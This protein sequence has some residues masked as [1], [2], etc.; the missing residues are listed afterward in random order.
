MIQLSSALR[1][2]ALSC[3]AVLL[4]G[5]SDSLDSPT[6]ALPTDEVALARKVGSSPGSPDKNK[7][8]DQEGGSRKSPKEKNQCDGEGGG[9]GGGGGGGDGPLWVSFGWNSDECGAVSPPRGDR[10]NVE[11]T[12]AM[13]DAEV[14]LSDISWSLANQ[15]DGTTWSAVDTY[16]DAFSSF[17][18]FPYDAF[19]CGSPGGYNAGGEILVLTGTVEIDGATVTQTGSYLFVDPRA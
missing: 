17:V 7:S 3:G 2:A 18:V 11:L 1:M 8:C 9:G 6:T 5:C 12:D 14:G 13:K 19:G 16:E 4:F 10:L 15:T